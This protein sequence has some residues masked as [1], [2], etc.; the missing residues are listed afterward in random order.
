MTQVSGDGF[1]QF[2]NGQWVPTE[3]QL[4]ALSNGATPYV[5]EKEIPIQNQPIHLTQAMDDDPN[6]ITNY[7][8]N[9]I[10]NNQYSNNFQNNIA[11]VQNNQTLN[12]QYSNNPAN[13]DHKNT[14]S[15]FVFTTKMKLISG[16]VIVALLTT[17]MILFA[18]LSPGTSGLVDELRDS[19]GDGITDADEIEMGTDPEL[20]DSDNDDL[21]DDVDDCP[22]GDTG[23]K[24]TI[25]T[26]F[27]QDGCK[28]STEDLDDD[29]DG[30]NDL[31]DNCDTSELG[32]KSNPGDDNDSDGCHDDGDA[33]DDNDGWSD[34]KEQ[35]CGT[36]SLSKFSIPSDFDG[37]MI[38][39]TVD[40]DDDNDGVL[41]SQD[42]FPM[43]SSEWADFDEDGIGDN[44]D[45]DDDND[46]V[47]DTLDMN[48]Y[49]D[50]G[51]LLT[52]DTFKVITKMDYWDNEA[53]V[54]ICTYVN[55]SNVGCGPDQ[56]GYHWSLTTST[57]YSLGTEI[58]VDLPE[59][60]SYH[61]I[62][63]CAWDND[64]FDDDRIDISTSSS[65]NCY[66]FNFYTTYIHSGTITA[67]GEGDGQGW[68]G[69]MVF[70]YEVTDLRNQ[71]IQ[72][73]Q[74]TIDGSTYSM[75]IDLDYSTY[76]YYRSLDHTVTGSTAEERY[77]RFPTPDAQYVIEIANQIE[78]LA[79]QNGYTTELEKAEFLFAFVGSIQY[80]LDIEGSGVSNYPK[81]S[82]EMLWEASGDC[83]DSAIL[84]VSLAEAMGLDAVFAR[85]LVKQSS[86][87]DW[88]GHAW[89][90]VK[91]D[92]ASGTYVTGISGK[93]DTRFY[94]VETTGYYDG[95]S[96]IGHNPWYDI[97]DDSYYDVE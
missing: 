29:N 47:V 26:D 66:S 65:N 55:G 60:S 74:W 62:S 56:T 89:A 61:D 7:Q 2:E 72:N 36:N 70:S 49:A 8:S 46:G 22:V 45:I 96:Y 82:I 16:G 50:V 44:S 30:I 3:M 10:S 97:T 78:D 59:T 83:E 28:D 34:S 63:I 12:N 1:W 76:T 43:D 69:E 18:T 92:D 19:D 32:W 33:D 25:V 87:E 53:E 95:Y 77:A 73:F 71:R 93:V 15:K 6:Q 67:S 54:Y 20:R 57:T 64:A 4:E 37:D 21:D 81:Y 48:D 27:D 13:Y 58:F 5:E 88:G 51:I 41:D 17:L 80:V 40:T 42:L 39:D 75:N 52:Y 79:I 84:Y 85:G 11:P 35:Q 90:M 86:D 31:D 94:F 23:W 14:N 9:Q 91:A 68:D 38:C 24:S